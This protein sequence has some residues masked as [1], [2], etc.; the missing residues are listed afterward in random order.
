MFMSL[1]CYDV[2]LFVG[3]CVGDSDGSTVSIRQRSHIKS[4][5]IIMLHQTWNLR[6]FRHL[7]YVRKDGWFF[8]FFDL[9]SPLLLFR[10]LRYVFSPLIKWFLQLDMSFN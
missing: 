3:F 7:R 4:L 2:W 9:K 8:A 1:T 10:L 5:F 6:Y